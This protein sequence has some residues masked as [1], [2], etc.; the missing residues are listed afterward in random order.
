MHAN[1]FKLRLL[2]GERLAGLFCFSLSAQAADALAD[3]GFDFLLFDTEHSPTGLT[4]LYSQLLA[5]GRGPTQPIVRVIANDAV[6]F[7]PVLDMGVDTLMVPNVRSAA[8]AE[9]AVGAMRYPPAGQRG[10]GG[11]VRAT[12]YGRDASYYAA[13]AERACLIV[14]VESGE[15]LAELEA[16]CAVPGVDCVLFG[17]ADLSTGLG[18]LAQ[19]EHPAVVSAIEDGIRRVR[20]AGKFAGVVAAGETAQRYLDA[21]ATMLCLGADLGIMVKACDALAA[22]WVLPA[23]PDDSAAAASPARLPSGLPPS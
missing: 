23:T 4:L 13:A 10:I 6:V 18:Y 8:E 9:A 15:G 3:C 1:R 21:G 17:P 12:R 14:Q 20:K 11:T 2:R 22:Q 7:K 19:P 16:I 5:L